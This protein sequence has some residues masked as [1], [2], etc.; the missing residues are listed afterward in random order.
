MGEGEGGFR[1]KEGRM[2]TAC[3]RQ[4]RM[5]AGKAHMAEGGRSTK[6]T[7]MIDSLQIHE[8]LI[9]AAPAFES[10]DE[11]LVKLPELNRSKL[12]NEV[13][14]DVEDG[15]TSAIAMQSM[16]TTS[17]IVLPDPIEATVSSS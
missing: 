9:F 15:G 16:I 10:T 11:T 14:F 3:G 1:E 13:H 5:E 2:R 6:A 7:L 17:S 12:C 4:E 8:Q